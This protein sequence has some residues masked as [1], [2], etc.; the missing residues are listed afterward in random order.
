PF[1]AGA[2]VRLFQRI[3]LFGTTGF[4]STSFTIASAP[5]STL[6]AVRYTPANPA[7]TNAVIEVEFSTEVA[8]GPGLI[9]LNPQG[10]PSPGSAIPTRESHPRPRVL[11]LT[12]LAPLA[13]RGYVIA[14]SP[15][16]GGGYLRFQATAATTPPPVSM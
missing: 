5:T 11:R 12:P 2:V 3:T 13:P 16:A 4:G 1:A 8:T 10:Y 7:P 9:T 14:V 6:K 15:K